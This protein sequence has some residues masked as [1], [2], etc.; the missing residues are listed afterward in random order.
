MKQ[1]RL[2][3]QGKGGAIGLLNRA[4]LVLCGLM[5]CGW[6]NLSGGADAAGV[7]S[8]QLLINGDFEKGTE[9]WD[10]VW[11]REAGAAKAVLDAAERHGGVRALRI[12]HTGRQDWSLKHS[13]ELKVQPGE[14]YELSAWVRV[15]G[16]GR[17]TLGV[18]TRDAAGNTIDSSY[19]GRSTAE[20]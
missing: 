1:A 6:P 14:I 15:R 17:V 10:P 16:A 18:V 9:G 11:A 3:G 13:L 19:G 5:V 4:M 7:H 12:E 2:R 20:T 8:E